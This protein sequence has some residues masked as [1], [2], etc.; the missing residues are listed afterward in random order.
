MKLVSV[1]IDPDHIGF[2]E[3]F[4]LQ[5]SIY[6]LTLY[7]CEMFSLKNNICVWSSLYHRF[8]KCVKPKQRSVSRSIL[9]TR[10]NSKQ[11]NIHH[12]QSCHFLWFLVLCATEF[13]G[14]TS[15]LLARQSQPFFKNIA[16]IYNIVNKLN[17]EVW[18]AVQKVWPPMI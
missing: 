5:S 10:H 12:L 2:A 13:Q 6:R 18:P 16:H 8:F 17:Y 3:L 7:Q 1:G 14:S 15:S 4:D 11:S 9:I